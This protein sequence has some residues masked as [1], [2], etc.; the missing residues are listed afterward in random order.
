MAGVGLFVEVIHKW[1]EKGSYPYAY[2]IHGGIG[3]ACLYGCLLRILE[4]AKFADWFFYASLLHVVTWTLH[5]SFTSPTER[6]RV[7]V[8][9]YAIAG[10]ALFILS[11]IFSNV[12]SGALVWTRYLLLFWLA[13]YSP[14]AIKSS[15]RMLY[16]KLGLWNDAYDAG[17]VADKP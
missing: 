13:L 7:R 3:V 8:V 1:L 2:A 10:P 6:G 4:R 5:D 16:V 17:D 15:D 11:E 9:L 12:S 14:L